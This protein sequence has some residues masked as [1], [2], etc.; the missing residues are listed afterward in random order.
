MRRRS[1][2]RGAWSSHCPF[3]LEK[4]LFLPFQGIFVLSH[5]GNKDCCYGKRTMELALWTQTQLILRQL[6][7]FTRK[8]AIFKETTQT[9]REREGK[10]C[11]ARSLEFQSTRKTLRVIN[12]MAEKN[13][14]IVEE[15]CQ[16]AVTMTWPENDWG[17]SIAV[18]CC[19]RAL[20]Q[21][22]ATRVYAGECAWIYRGTKYTIQIDLYVH[23]QSLWGQNL[24]FNRTNS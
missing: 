20:H 10:A 4:H 5:P 13:S 18:L 19:E 7:V 14:F 12:K 21:L 15:A 6:C 23:V 22:R 8:I 24:L 17:D 2:A 9:D 1:L 11:K 16:F 3:M